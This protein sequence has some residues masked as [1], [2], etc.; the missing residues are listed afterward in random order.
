MLLG[1]GG[2]VGAFAPNCG[3]EAVISDGRE[4]RMCVRSILGRAARSLS[5]VTALILSSPI[6]KWHCH[7]VQKP[8][9]AAQGGP[10]QSKRCCAAARL[11]WLHPRSKIADPLNS[12]WLEPR[13]AE[14]PVAAAGLAHGST[15]HRNGYALALVQNNQPHL[16]C[17]PLGSAFAT[18]TGNIL[19]GGGAPSSLLVQWVAS[20][21]AP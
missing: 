16:A 20:I 11:H 1:S 8:R 3:P 19:A 9:N 12:A 2:L 18:S 15:G 17:T 13:A 4:V 7:R 5:R 14:R 21:A 6:P 10:F